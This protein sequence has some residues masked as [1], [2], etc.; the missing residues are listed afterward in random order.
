MCRLVDN[1]STGMENSVGKFGGIS[2]ALEMLSAH[3]AWVQI[4]TGSS[5]SRLKELFEC[6]FNQT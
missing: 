2:M 5:N 3:P 1:R 4:C 6:G